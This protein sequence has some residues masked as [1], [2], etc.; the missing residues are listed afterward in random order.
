MTNVESSFECLY[1]ALQYPPRNVLAHLFFPPSFLWKIIK[2]VFKNR[3]FVTEYHPLMHVTDWLMI[4]LYAPGFIT[5]L[6]NCKV[7]NC[8][9]KTAIEKSSVNPFILP[10]RIVYFFMS[11]SETLCG[12]SKHKTKTKVK[13]V[14]PKLMKPTDPRNPG[15]LSLDL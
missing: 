5:I 9:T 12:V 15:H 14:N 11:I 1:I 4:S 8:D 10:Y 13:L 3:A 6:S 2:N 7:K